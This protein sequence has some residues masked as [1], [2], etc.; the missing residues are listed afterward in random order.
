MEVRDL[1]IPLDVAILCVHRRGDVLP[2]KGGT[3]LEEGDLLTLSGPAPSVEVAQ[4]KLQ[5]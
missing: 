2:S 5:G 4:R 1:P 3:R